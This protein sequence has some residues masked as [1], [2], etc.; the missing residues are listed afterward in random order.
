MVRDGADKSVWRIPG[1]A[2]LIREDADGNYI[3]LVDMFE[4]QSGNA[5][6]LN[7]RRPNGTLPPGFG[8]QP[9]PVAVNPK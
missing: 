9:V 6:V 4:F 8:M 3:A 7:Q 1:N 5:P 2:W